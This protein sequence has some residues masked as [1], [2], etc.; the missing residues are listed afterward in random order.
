M[1]A[2]LGLAVLDA[3]GTI[4][5]ADAGFER[6]AGAKPGASAGRMFF[7]D[8]DLSED[9]RRHGRTRLASALPLD[10][11][12]T[13]PAFGATRG[14]I[15]VRFRSVDAGTG[16][17]TAVSVEDAGETAHLRAV[18]EAYERALGTASHV[19]HEINNSLM[20]ILGHLEL[21]LAEASTPEP[22]RRRAEILVAEVERIRVGIAA[23]QTIRRE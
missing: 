3:A 16:R 2:P 17:L 13:V 4:L 12:F 5:A 7:D 21:L 23:L 9:L 14:Q 10:G 19:R 8:P 20:S 11:D 18:E 22:V 1:S 6:L 15:L